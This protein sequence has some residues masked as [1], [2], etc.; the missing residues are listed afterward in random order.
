[1]PF[2]AYELLFGSNGSYLT[3][4]FGSSDVASFTVIDYV[5]AYWTKILVPAKRVDGKVITVLSLQGIRI[6]PMKVYSAPAV[7]AFTVY[8]SSE[9]IGFA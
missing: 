1:M 6:F 4:Q 8:S 2:D 5:P 3:G 9:P 7:F